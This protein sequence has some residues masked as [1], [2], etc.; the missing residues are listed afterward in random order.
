MKDCVDRACIL[1][2]GFFLNISVML[3]DELVNTNR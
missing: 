2:D 1:F 3:E